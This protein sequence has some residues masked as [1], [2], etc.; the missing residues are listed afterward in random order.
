MNTQDICSHGM[1]THTH[2]QQDVDYTTLM[3]LYD[4]HATDSIFSILSD[5]ED[6]SLLFKAM[7]ELQ[8]QQ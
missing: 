1:H 2:T 7:I 6:T 8:R 3:V 5:V 4:S